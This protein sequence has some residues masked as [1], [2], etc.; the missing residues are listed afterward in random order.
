MV[1]EPT[2]LHTTIAR[3]LQPPGQLK[4]RVSEW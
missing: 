4:E 2:I 1:K 3:L